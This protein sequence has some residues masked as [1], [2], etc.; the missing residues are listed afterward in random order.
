[1]RD[2]DFAVR[3][4][5]RIRIARDLKGLTLRQLAESADVAASTVSRLENG[6]GLITLDGFV[7][8]CD[9]MGIDPARMLPARK[10]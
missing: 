4:G 10:K 9:A 1:M 6:T 8:L 2:K 5:E 3:L 7:R